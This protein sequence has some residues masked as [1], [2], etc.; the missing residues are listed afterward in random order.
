MTICRYCVRLGKDGRHIEP[1]DYPSFENGCTA[2]ELIP[3][4]EDGLDERDQLLL[5]DQATY[6]LGKSYVLCPRFRLLHPDAPLP[7]MAGVRNSTKST[8]PSAD[9]ILDPDGEV[10]DQ[11]PTP[12]LWSGLAAMLLLFFLCGGSVAAYTGW[13]LVGRGLADLGRDDNPQT[14]NSDPVVLLV[15]ASAD[16][17]SV[18]SPLASPPPREPAAVVFPPAVT[19]TPDR[20]VGGPAPV[21]ITTPISGDPPAEDD[22]ELGAPDLATAVNNLVQITTPS[23]GPAI[24]TPRPTPAFLAATSTSIPIPQVVVVT[25]TAAPTTEPASVS[26]RAA[27]ETVLPGGCTILSWEVKN[28]R[29]VFFE[30]QGVAGTGEQKVCQRYDS[31][32]YTLSVL[33]MDGTQEDHHIT[34]RLIPHTVT[35]TITPTMTPVLTPTPTWTPQGTATVTPEPARFAVSLS[36]DGGNLKRCEPGTTCEAILQVTNGG[37]LTDEIF[38]DLNK[39]GPW[40]AQIC[41]VDGSCGDTAVSLGVGAGDRQPIYLRAEIPGDAAGQSFTYS[42]VAASGNSHQ[43]VRSEPITVILSVP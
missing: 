2:V 23:T 14:L 8:A 39:D 38:V 4:H 37:S 28:V 12:G 29:A 31:Q 15:T 33:H 34:V 43:S 20:S 3:A 19:P 35:P 32:S 22:G 25:A 16:S 1:A 7:D 10:L 18:V 26:F 40:S 13:Q 30:D 11:R 9:L 6:C 41:R 21:V 24:P 36:A 17:Q 42:V 5:A 27:N